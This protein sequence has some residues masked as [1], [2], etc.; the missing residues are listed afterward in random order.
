MKGIRGRNKQEEEVYWEKKR[1]PM[2][3]HNEW[4][5]VFVV[6]AGRDEEES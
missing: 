3:S 6:V 4:K 1:L 2:G 5:Y